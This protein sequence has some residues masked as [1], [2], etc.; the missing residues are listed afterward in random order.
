[1]SRATAQHV[2]TPHRRTSLVATSTML[3]AASTAQAA[4]NTLA[5][6]WATRVLGPAP[7]G[8]MV[9]ALTIATTA[10]LLGGAGSGSAYRSELASAHGA[11]RTR[12]AAGY[13]AIV[14]AGSGAAA[15]LAV[16][17]SLASAGAIASE[18]AST[19]LLAGV[20]VSTAVQSVGALTTEA[21][22]ADGRFRQ[23][24]GWAAGS[25]AGGLAGLMVAAAAGPTPATMLIGQAAGML[26]VTAASVN[27]LL[28]TGALA[29]PRLGRVGRLL[30]RGLP[31]LGFSVGLTVALRAD[32]Y[33][34]GVIAGPAA[35]TVYSLAATLGEIARTIPQAIGQVFSRRVAERTE[36]T[37]RDAALTAMVA[38]AVTA[39][40]VGV[41]SWYAIPSFFGDDLAAAR[42]YLLLML[43]AELLF[44]PFT[45]A[46]KGLVGGGWTGTVGL[47]GCLGS[48]VAIGAFLALARPFGVWGACAASCLTYTTLSVLAYGNVRRLLARRAAGA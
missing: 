47:I 21:W 15:V 23:A 16:V 43:L 44:T 29:A 31:A 6:L 36:A 30:R 38:A 18:L 32:R 1:M 37:P 3:G 13:A 14:V 26:P 41:V 17:A 48:A 5:A 7:R 9:V 33:L 11:A 42:N 35:I 46:A 8:V 25:A 27:R 12:L 19:P 45:V 34:L 39:L 20:A 24:G 2:A 10:A 4:A 40:P 28:R 22:F